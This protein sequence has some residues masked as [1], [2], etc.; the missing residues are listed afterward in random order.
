MNFRNVGTQL[1]RF[2]SNSGNNSSP[3]LQGLQGTVSQRHL[4]GE[5]PQATF[6]TAF[7]AKSLARYAVAAIATSIIGCKPYCQ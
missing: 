3:R 6:K 7:E 2:T 1:T 5:S 4:A